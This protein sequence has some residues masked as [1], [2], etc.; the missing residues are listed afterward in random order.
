[1]RRIAS[2]IF[3][4]AIL[5]FQLV[6]CAS[7]GFED[8]SLTP[9]RDKY[10]S[11][12]AKYA[13]RLPPQISTGGE[14]A[15]LVDP[16]VH[17]WGAYDSSGRLVRAGLASAGAKW[18]ND[19]KAPCKT[20]PG[21]YRISFLGNEECVSSL[22]PLEKGGA[23]MPYCMFFNETQALHGSPNVVEGNISHGCVRMRKRDAEWVRYDFAGYDT[24]VIV[25]PY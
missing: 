4:L 3:F 17:A 1:M 6:S 13:S 22:Y 5:S 7:L 8:T 14:R 20:E 24:K 2:N 16:N 19:I 9:A 18:C 25:T 12:D 10:R 21:T 23:P 15:I 11:K